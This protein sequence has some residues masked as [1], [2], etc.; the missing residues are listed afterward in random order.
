MIY[1]NRSGPGKIKEMHLIGEVKN[2]R[3]VII[4]DMIDSGGTLCK[5]C[6]LLISSGAKSVEAYCTHAIL[7]GKAEYNISRSEISKIYVTNTIN[8]HLIKMIPKVE[9]LSAAPLFAEAIKG[10]HNERSL[11][12]LFDV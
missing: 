8:N 3:C 9:M 11:S 12:Y 7:S 5:A 1:K 2:K 10:V 6:S 4:D